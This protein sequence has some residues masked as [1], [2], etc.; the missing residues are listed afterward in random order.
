M[1]TYLVTGGAGF[2][3]CNL[4]KELL[5]RGHKV[6][7]L[8]N[9][10]TG[11]RENLL[12]YVQDIELLEG[13]FSSYHIVNKAVKGVDF[14]LHQGALPSVPRSINDPITSTN[15]NING[16]LNLL[17]ASLEAGVHRF[18]YASSSSVYG[19]SEVSPK[20]EELKLNPKSPYA[21]S[22]LTGEYYCRVYYQLFGLPAVA[23]RYFN[24]FGPRQNPFSQ[25][26]AVIPKFLQLMKEGKSPLIHGDGTQSRDFTY[27]ENNVNANLMAC[28]T[29][30]IGGEAMNIACGGSYTLLEL[31]EALNR[32]LGTRITPTF[33]ESRPG[34]V[35]HSK[36][37][38]SHAQ[39]LM[40][41]RVTVDF[42]EGLRRLVAD[43]EQ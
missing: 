43:F 28:E 3:G 1:A 11:R 5:K 16:T 42:E 39:K 26:S 21:I 35:K 13:D 36:A 14:V 22:K 19:D 41:Y 10:A 9:F 12:P 24:V 18:V 7:V 37:D 34:D 20:H 38:I 8:D 27:V 25:Y 2:I 30:G 6:R 33:S 23:L 15:V 4:V 31:V 32:I 29:E 40:G 17:Q